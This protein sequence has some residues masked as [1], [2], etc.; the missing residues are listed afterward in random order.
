[1]MTIYLQEEQQ[2]FNE[3]IIT[4]E[5]WINGW[6]LTKTTILFEKVDS[7]WWKDE[8]ASNGQTIVVT[9]LKKALPFCTITTSLHGI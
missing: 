8:R 6:H 2:N 4:L 7:L 1:M 5:H 3:I 9:A